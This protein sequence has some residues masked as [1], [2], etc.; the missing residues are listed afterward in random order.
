MRTILIAPTQPDLA[1]APAEIQDV[2]GLLRADPVLGVV[3]LARLFRE[4][5]AQG[6]KTYELIWFASHGDDAGIHLSDSVVD[7]DTLA[8]ALRGTNARLIVLNTCSSERAAEQLYSATNVP[9]LCNVGP[10]ADTAAYATA[11]RFAQEIAGGLDVARAFSLAKTKTFRLIPDAPAM[12]SQNSPDM[13]R[14][15]QR[16]DTAERTIRD[17]QAVLY[18]RP[19]EPGIVAEWAKMAQR[20]GELRTVLWALVAM[21]LVMAGTLAAVLASVWSLI[22]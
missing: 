15:T 4:L 7:G 2:I 21:M 6:G 3:D 1:M 13:D 11:H 16:M 9:I 17:H 12:Y 10:V 22:P 18:G 19:G 14:L 20:L 5:R 8:A